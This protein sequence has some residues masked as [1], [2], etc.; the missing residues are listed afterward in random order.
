M[1]IKRFLQILTRGTLDFRAGSLFFILEIYMCQKSE[2]KLFKIVDYLK[3]SR[4]PKTLSLNSTSIYFIILFVFVFPFTLVHF[5]EQWQFQ[6]KFSNRRKNKTQV[7]TQ[8][9]L[10]STWKSTQL[11]KSSRNQEGITFPLWWHTT[12]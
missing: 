9:Y 2:I 5:A 1:H 8:F 11:A 12:N 6:C 3:R 10:W 4:D 7:S